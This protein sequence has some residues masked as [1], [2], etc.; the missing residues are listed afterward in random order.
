[1]YDPAWVDVPLAGDDTCTVMA[2]KWAA[3]GDEV[4]FSVITEGGTR[5]TARLP[6]ACLSPEFPLDSGSLPDLW[7]SSEQSYVF[8]EDANDLVRYVLRDGSSLQVLKWVWQLQGPDVVFGVLFHGNVS[9]H[10]GF[11]TPVLRFPLSLLYGF[12]PPLKYDPAWV[13]VPLV[14]GDVCTV[15]AHEWVVD[16]EEVVF[17][18]VVEEGAPLETVRLPAACFGSEHIAGTIPDLCDDANRSWVPWLDV[19][20]PQK[21][22]LWD[23]ST[24]QVLTDGW[25]LEG[26]MAVFSLPFREGMGLEWPALRFPTVL[27]CNFDGVRHW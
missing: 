22:D 2:H 13:D 17:R 18:L 8:T 4:V 12:N 7:S 26:P 6:V 25:W 16:G 11:D 14:N 23:G 9:L 1:M 10:M 27:L 15:M 21:F 20:D 3:D 19:T 5:E 24:L